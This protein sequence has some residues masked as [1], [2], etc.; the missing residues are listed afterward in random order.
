MIN[1]IE[2]NRQRKHIEMK[3]AFEAFKTGIKGWMKQ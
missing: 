3:Q 2:L 1:L